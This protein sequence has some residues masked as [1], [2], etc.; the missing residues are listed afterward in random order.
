[1]AEDR[2]RRTAVESGKVECGK[3]DD[4]GLTAE[5]G[6]GR[7]SSPLQRSRMK[8]RCWY[9]NGTCLEYGGMSPARGGTHPECSGKRPKIGGRFPKHGGDVPMDGGRCSADHR[10]WLCPGRTS[11]AV[12]GS[13]PAGIGAQSDHFGSRAAVGNVSEEGGGTR[14][15]NSA[16]VARALRRL[17]KQVGLGR[18]RFRGAEEG[19]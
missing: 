12:G 17:R 3:V 9:K 18:D 4:G 1:M 8:R 6:R 13:G 5:D 19:D 15:A 10:A 2:R 14:R 11:P 7:C 16:E